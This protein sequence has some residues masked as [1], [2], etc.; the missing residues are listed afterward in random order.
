MDMKRAIVLFVLFIFVC[1]PLAGV[2]AAEK[3]HMHFGLKVGPSFST[4]YAAGG[5]ANF[6]TTFAGGAFMTYNLSTMFQIQPEVLYVGRGWKET[7]GPLIL[8]NKIDYIDLSLLLKLAVPTQGKVSSSLGVGPY[9]GL[10]ISDGWDF[11]VE[12]PAVVDE[13]IQII[14]DNLKST[15]IGIVVTGEVDYAMNNGD[16]ILFDM[17]LTYGL[18]K[19]FDTISVSG[20]PIA[21]LDLKNMGFQVLAGYAF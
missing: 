2:S 6:R 5:R 3:G 15:D 16:A 17:R 11:N 7:A 1:A 4:A 18:Q 9:F 13:A 19:I 8:T 10:K 21:T 12:L 14:Y 20:T